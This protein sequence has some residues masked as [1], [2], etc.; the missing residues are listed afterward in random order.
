[1]SALR[2]WLRAHPRPR[3]LAVVVAL[4]GALALV[5]WLLVPSPASSPAARERAS[6]ASQRPP[7]ASAARLAAP[8]ALDAAS[9]TQAEQVAEA[10]LVAYAGSGTGDSP[11][12]LRSRLRPY[13]TDRLDAT[14]GQG[15]G[16]GAAAAQGAT[17]LR[18]QRLSSLGLGPD[19]RLVM[20]ALVA[21]TAQSGQGGGARYVE[22]F[23][24]RGSADWRVDEVSL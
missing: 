14:L 6:T 3:A 16:A 21:Q 19:G 1:V 17:G 13:D 15:G 20:V 18:V 10:F 11:A 22:L 5:L 9:L 12:A 24:A 23:L 8:A 4:T 2:T 7:A